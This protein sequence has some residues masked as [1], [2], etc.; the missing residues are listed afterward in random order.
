MPL[1]LFLWLDYCCRGWLTNNIYIYI[2]IYIYFIKKKQQTGHIRIINLFHPIMLCNVCYIEKN[3]NVHFWIVFLSWWNYSQLRLTG[4][5]NTYI[6][7][8]V[9][10]CVRV[11]FG[12]VWLF[13]NVSVFIGYLIS[14]LYLKK[15]SNGTTKT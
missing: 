4:P 13:D 12:L 3:L 9:R 7:I 14:Q 6:Y 10:A 11:W 5:N 2:Y 8:C 1:Y 15:I